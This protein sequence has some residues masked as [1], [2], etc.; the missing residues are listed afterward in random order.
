MQ[1]G[2][3]LSGRGPRGKGELLFDNLIAVGLGKAGLAR[4]LT[5]CFLMG[6]DM[7]ILSTRT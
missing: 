2:N 7:K 3:K 4:A 5:T 6:G 1:G